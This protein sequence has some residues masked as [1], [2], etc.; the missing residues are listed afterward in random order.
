[1][2]VCVCVVGVRACACVCVCVCMCVCV[3]VL[4]VCVR[5]C[6]GGCGCVIT[7]VLVGDTN[8]YLYGATVVTFI[9]LLIGGMLLSTSGMLQYDW[10]LS[11]LSKDTTCLVTWED[12]QTIIDSL[13]V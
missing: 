11:E 13:R 10:S 4:W 8:N 12:N 2:C 6:V 3:Y 9:K 7:T 5:V 1:M